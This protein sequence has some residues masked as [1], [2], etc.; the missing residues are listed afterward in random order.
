MPTPIASLRMNARGLAA[1]G[2][3]LFSAFAIGAAAGPAWAATPGRAEQFHHV[4]MSPGDDS[5]SMSGG[6]AG[7]LGD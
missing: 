1:A 6:P 5:I 2:A 3:L 4:I 7:R